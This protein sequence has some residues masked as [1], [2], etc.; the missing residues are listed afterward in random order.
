MYRKDLQ[1]LLLKDK[2]PNFFFLYGAD[3]FQSELY[4]NFIKQKWNTDET[5]KIFFEEYNFSRV[6]DFLSGGSLFSEKKLLEIKTN[7]KIPS[8]EL[9][10]L[11]ELCKQNQD[12]FLLLELYD[13]SSKQSDIE[14]IFENNFV[15]FF[16]ANNAKEGVE[17]LAMK[18]KELNIEITQNALF[19]LFS[20]FDENLYLA[21]SELNKFQDLSIDEKT[22]EKYC[23]SLSV[24]GFEMFF[25]KLLQGKNINTDLEKILD[26]FNE[27][28]LIN[29][30]NTNFYRLFKIAL[31]AKI[32]G[33]MDFKELLG[34]TPPAQ[35]A[36]KL[37]LQA[38]GIKISQY[39]QIFTLLLES[40]YELKN[41]SKLS[42][43]EFL[44]ATLLKLS[45]ILKTK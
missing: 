42:K 22:I 13:E 20:N 12:N 10:I 34:Y 23:F 38:F 21:A 39:Q 33:K 36:K 28:A 1:N 24:V 32:H 3:N 45:Q 16:K 7:K 14:K 17:L 44:I 31:Y 6:S 4:A 30:L 19:A 5:L 2:F 11:I 37:E 27:I 8:K 43:K 15:R 18:A 35:V 40:E 9:K 25:E 26:S 41:N 29:S